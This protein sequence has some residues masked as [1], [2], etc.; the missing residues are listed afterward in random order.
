MPI[1]NKSMF[2]KLAVLTPSEA[3]IQSFDKAVSALLNKIHQ[4]AQENQTL[5]SLR[6][7]LLPKLLSGEIEL[8]VS[9]ITDND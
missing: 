8:D 1:I 4:N 3:L 9:E 7:T 5:S 2:E 6:D